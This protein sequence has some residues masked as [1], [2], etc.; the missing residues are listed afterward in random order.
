MFHENER[1]KMFS[2]CK[3]CLETFTHLLTF[4]YHLL[5]F[6]IF[7]HFLPA[8][9]I[10]HFNHNDTISYN[11]YGDGFESCVPFELPY[12]VEFQNNFPSILKTLSSIHFSKKKRRE[13]QD[14]IREDSNGH[15]IWQ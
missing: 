11:V 14:T 5:T 8:P 2:P 6:N 7:F 4:P 15:E 12:F 10:R 3:S 1:K 13:N 9:G